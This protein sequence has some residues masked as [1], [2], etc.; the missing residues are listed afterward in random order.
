MFLSSENH[1]LLRWTLEGSVGK[2]AGKSR[3][4]CNTIELDT[5]MI[6]VRYLQTK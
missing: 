4:H 6:E 2:A 5:E 3:D 1:Q